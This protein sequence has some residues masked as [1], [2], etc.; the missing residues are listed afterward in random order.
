MLIANNCIK[1]DNCKH[2]DEDVIDAFTRAFG[3][4]LE[5]SE[6]QDRLNTLQQYKS[7][8]TPISC[9]S[10]QMIDF[11]L[12]TATYDTHE[13]DEHGPVEIADL[14]LDDDDSNDAVSDN[15]ETASDE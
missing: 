2:Q 13:L 15:W 11:D 6:C 8:G 4:G 9:S 10:M 5:D 3:L 1:Y 12:R 14:R 7:N